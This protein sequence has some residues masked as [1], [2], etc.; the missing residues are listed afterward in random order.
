[1]P[2][3]MRNA[4]IPDDLQVSNAET[5]GRSVHSYATS[6]LTGC[7]H[8]PHLLHQ[9]V[10]VRWILAPLPEGWPQLGFHDVH[11]TENGSCGHGGIRCLVKDGVL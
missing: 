3:P 11:T 6:M 4:E 9:H 1:M 5:K 2:K 8:H 7:C 10:C